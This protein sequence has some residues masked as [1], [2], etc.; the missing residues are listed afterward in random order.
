MS[1]R[2]PEQSDAS[3]IANWALSAEDTARWC[4]SDT[5]VPA[6]R[7]IEWWSGSDVEPWLLVDALGEPIAYGEL[8][9]DVDEDEVELARLIVAPPL[10]S[11]GVGRRLVGELLGKAADTGLG[12]V[13]L[14]VRPGNEVAIRCYLGSGFVDVGPD[15][16]AEFNAGQPVPYVWMEHIRA[17]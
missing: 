3:V 13:F 16:T 17:V 7:V 6:E 9:V 10:R 8:W 5:A 15:R 1:V 4:S 12:A 11:R 14:R 2:R